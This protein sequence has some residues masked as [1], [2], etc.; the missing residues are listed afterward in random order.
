VGPIPFGSNPPIPFPL[1]A[2]PNQEKREVASKEKRG[3]LLVLTAPHL[4]V[5]GRT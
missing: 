1:E 5:L 3:G 4:S 2:T